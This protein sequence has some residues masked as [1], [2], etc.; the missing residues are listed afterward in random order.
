M[1]T[2]NPKA[3][4]AWYTLMAEA[5]RGTSEAKEAFNALSEMSST[6]E[7]FNKWMAQFMPGMAATMKMQPDGFEEQMETWWRMMGVVPRARYLD[8]LEKCDTLER[9]LEK[10][11]KTAESLRK[12]LGVQEQ[13][14]EEAK[15]VMDMWGTI[16]QDTLKTQTEWMKAWTSVNKPAQSPAAESPAPSEQDP[17]N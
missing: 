1:Y 3:L 17:E 4:E 5:M 11:E 8:L 6:P 13:Q 10:A 12:R 15:K 14:E 7:D 16:M 9:K 2:P